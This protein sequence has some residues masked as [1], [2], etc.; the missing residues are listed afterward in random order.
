MMGA[1]LRCKGGH[2]LGEGGGIRIAELT[3][4]T[5]FTPYLHSISNHTQMDVNPCTL[6]DVVP[7]VSSENGGPTELD[8][9]MAVSLRYVS[10]FSLFLMT[11]VCFF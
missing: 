4:S 9:E 1:E 6:H 11:K 10:Y 5:V 3:K 2:A 8:K 7:S